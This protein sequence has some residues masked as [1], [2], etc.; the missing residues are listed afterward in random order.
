MMAM[1]QIGQKE[2]KTVSRGREEYAFLDLHPP[3]TNDRAPKTLLR[4]S[5]IADTTFKTPPP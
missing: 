3:P 2:R 5:V 4:R 1:S